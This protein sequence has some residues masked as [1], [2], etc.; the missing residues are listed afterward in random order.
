MAKVTD[1]NEFQDVG[2][3]LQNNTINTTSYTTIATPF[4]ISSTMGTTG[5][6]TTY[7]GVVN[8]NLFWVEPIRFGFTIRFKTSK[9]KLIR[10]W[11]EHDYTQGTPVKLSNELKKLI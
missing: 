6:W 11:K 3:S 8:P 4:S 5:T 10:D 9:A 1:H 2:L 7:S